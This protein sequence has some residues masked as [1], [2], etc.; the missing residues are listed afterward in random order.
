MLLDE[1]KAAVAAGD[2]TEGFRYWMVQQK[3]DA[4]QRLFQLTLALEQL[5]KEGGAS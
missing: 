2:T 1:W 5:R 4:E 3:V